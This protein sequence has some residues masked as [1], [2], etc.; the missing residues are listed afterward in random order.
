[1]VGDP[2]IPP[3]DGDVNAKLDV[4]IAMLNDARVTQSYD[5]K[6]ILD[7]IASFRQRFDEVVEDMES[8][9]QKVLR[10]LIESGQLPG[11]PGSLGQILRE[12]DK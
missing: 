3:I 9:L 1:M 6:S 2:P 5:T 4:I 8:T 11:L 7:A 10:Y 12:K